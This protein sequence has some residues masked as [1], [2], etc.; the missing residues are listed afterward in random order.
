MHGISNLKTAGRRLSKIK[1]GLIST[2]LVLAVLFGGWVV[3]QEFA[4]YCHPYGSINYRGETA[5]DNSR[6]SAFINGVEIVTGL[7]QNGQYDLLIPKDDPSTSKKEGWTENDT[8][9]IKIDGFTT[10]PSFAAFS[11]T[12]KIDLFLPSLDV[13]LTTWGKIKALFK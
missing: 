10:V 2:G 7:T 13:K 6:V 11:G 4:W 1:L 3:A 5:M 8:I 9:T 12:K